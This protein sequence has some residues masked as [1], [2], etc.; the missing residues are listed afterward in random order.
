MS[1]PPHRGRTVGV[2]SLMTALVALLGYFREAT[3]AAKF[4][5]SAAAD[6]YFGVVL[7]PNMLYGI[8]VL[9]TLSPVLIPILLEQEVGEDHSRVSDAF[10]AVATLVLV[11][12][13]ALVIGGLITAKYWLQWLFPGFSVST[14]AT[15][16]RL[17]YM[18]LPATLF[19]VMSG[20][21]T[22][23]L[24]GFHK[25][26]LAAFAPA[27][28]SI[29]VIAAALLARGENA[30]YYVGMATTSG[31]LLQFLFLIPATVSLGIR[32]RPTLQVRHPAIRRMLTL[33]T[34]LFL[35]LAV[36]NVTLIFERNL[37]SRLSAGAI[38]ALTYGLRL[39][40]V[41]A[42]F[43]A[44]PLAI[45]AYPQFAREALRDNHGDLRGQLSQTLRFVVFL[46]LPATVWTVL[47]ALPVV[48]VLYE[49]GHFHYGDSILISRVLMFYCIGILPNAIAV[50][51]IRCFYAM[52]DT[53]TPLWTEA[54]NLIFFVVC[55]TWLSRRFGISGLAFVRGTTFYLV[56][57]ILTL[58]LL[59]KKMLP[60]IDREAISFFGKTAAATAAMVLVNWA[61]G[62]L[63][64]PSFDR[65]GTPVRLL[66]IGILLVLSGATFLGVASLFKM[67]ETEK[68]F[69]TVSALFRG[70]V[71]FAPL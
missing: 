62:L 7:I 34:P 65:G 63:L 40:T 30:I 58:V 37:A 50:I 45:V 22:A 9:G 32:Y 70:A 61:G 8:L 3:L 60:T 54:L 55:A 31:F 1:P 42:N 53:I 6:A 64:R 41:P 57:A 21:F 38:S 36:A 27:L 39:F 43:L 18:V 19:L 66:E 68:L 71:K 24:N 14:L 10:S 26:A 69:R 2:V 52:K 5:I 35:Y 23:A 56:T 29:V 12:F 15:A 44:A 46:F 25:F 4:G 20:L 11:L 67:Q 13:A 49:R 33:G 48:R 47:N 59:R 28:G 17:L 51:L 16:L